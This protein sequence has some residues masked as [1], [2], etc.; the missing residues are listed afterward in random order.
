VPNVASD[1][2]ENSNFLSIWCLS[3]C[4]LLAAAD[5][6][7]L[8]PLAAGYWLCAFLVAYNIT[9]VLRA[10]SHVLETLLAAAGC[11]CR[12]LLANDYVHF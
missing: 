8:L 7:L 6:W 5:C 1:T 10:L 2:Q 11:C 9:F 3:G 12:W 4:W